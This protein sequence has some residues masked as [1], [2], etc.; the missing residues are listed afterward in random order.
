MRTI[1]HDKE[2]NFAGKVPKLLFI[3]AEWSTIFEQKLEKHG[4]KVNFTSTKKVSQWK[5]SVC[6]SNGALKSILGI[7]SQSCFWDIRVRINWLSEQKQKGVSAIC[8]LKFLFNLFI[9]AWEST[10]RHSYA[11]TCVDGAF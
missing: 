11:T 10:R 2:T 6:T 1:L 9:S 5:K 3:S 8:N 7:H 4:A